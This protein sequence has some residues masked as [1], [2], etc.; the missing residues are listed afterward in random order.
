MAQC[1]S[2]TN[3]ECP[4]SSTGCWFGHTA[5]KNT[6]SG[7]FSLQ[8]QEVK[9]NKN[10]YTKRAPIPEQHPTIPNPLACLNAYFP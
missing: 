7:A 8:C 9:Q 10:N 4:N 6:T 3:Y 5:P 1:F 2:H